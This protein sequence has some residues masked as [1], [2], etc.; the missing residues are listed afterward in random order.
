MPSCQIAGTA[1]GVV[2]TRRTGSSSVPS[3]AATFR[4]GGGEAF[5]E[6][7]ALVRDVDREERP[8]VLRRLLGDGEVQPIREPQQVAE[9]LGRPPHGGERAVPLRA[10][11]GREEVREEDALLCLR[12][13][14]HL[15][16]HRHHHRGVDETG[17]SLEIAVGGSVGRDPDR[18][19]HERPAPK[20]HGQLA[21]RVARDD[22]ELP[23]PVL[24]AMRAAHL[25]DAGIPPRDGLVGLERRGPRTH[26]A[27][28]RLHEQARD[29]LG[30][31]RRRQLR[32]HH[33]ELGAV[34]PGVARKEV[35][36]CLGDLP[37]G[38]EREADVVVL[39]NGGHGGHVRLRKPKAPRV[40]SS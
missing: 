37:A 7:E 35:A 17:E 36:R 9:A 10:G 32:E 6:R 14:L 18:G 33:A 2:R 39:E 21:D 28:V 40:L 31:L 15:R 16:Q 24:H 1:Y 23:R 30:I 20:S 25:E 3:F 5:G 11:L 13:R 38:R 34:R 4:G 29:L 8:N 12:E 26:V 19:V 22:A 27:V